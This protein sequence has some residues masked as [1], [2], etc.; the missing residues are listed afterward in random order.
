MSFYQ[1]S[2]TPSRPAPPPPGAGQ[3]GTNGS[4]YTNNSI[5]AS[6]GSSF[7]T[8]LQLTPPSP[9]S[10]SYNPAYSGIGGSP[11]RGSSATGY[12]DGQ[13]V[14]NGYVSVKEDGFASLFWSRKW[15]VL[16]EATLSF[17]KNEVRGIRYHHHYA[18]LWT[19]HADYVVGFSIELASIK[20]D[21]SRGRDS[22]R[23]CRAQ[24]VLPCR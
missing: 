4:A 9:A 8:S 14:R 7:S 16:R 22:H 15:L 11:N 24:A 6:S 17:H 12:S 5:Y 23:P 20:L 2:L 18:L 1:S 21:L 13:V 19:R 10:S 3:R